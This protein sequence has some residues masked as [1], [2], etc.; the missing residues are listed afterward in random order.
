MRVATTVALALLPFVS[1]CWPRAAASTP[2]A[3]ERT[4]YLMGTRARLVLL[5]RDRAAGLRRLEAMVESLEQ[6]EAELSTWR[7]D[8]ALSA[9]NRQP[10]D[11]PLQLPA[12]VCA[13]WGE[14]TAWHRATNG[15]FDPALGALSNAWGLRETGRRPSPGRLAAA[16]AVT[17]LTHFR[18]EASTCRVTR[19]AEVTLD[20]GAFGKGEALRRLHRQSA[21]GEPWMVDL[22]GQIVVSGVPPGGSWPVAIAHPARRDETT[23]EITLD[24]GSLATSGASERSYEIEGRMVAHI[25]D[26]RTGQPLYRPESVTV[27][28][29]DALIADILSTAL[30][31]LGPEAGLRY[32]DEHELAAL[33][34]APVGRGARA[35]VTL[36]ASPAF[37]QR[38]P[39]SARHGH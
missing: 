17:G 6:T 25:L 33:F 5:A 3:V 36:L 26:P 10:V 22:G 24:S 15:A 23:I 13:L 1:L 8:S 34:L 28:H 30:Y 19:L 29:A 39:A 32:A 4:V 27:W 9:L 16:R 35:S 14:L 11:E 2:H 31:V 37:R 21:G 20:A 12:P 7:T 18:F 38:F